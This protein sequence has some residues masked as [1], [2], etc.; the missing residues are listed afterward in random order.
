[1]VV[2]EKEVALQLSFPSA[3]WI[4]RIPANPFLGVGEFGD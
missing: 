4:R 1:L 3:L 2:E